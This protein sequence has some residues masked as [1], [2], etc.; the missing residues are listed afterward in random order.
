MFH[1]PVRQLWT[2]YPEMH[3]KLQLMNLEISSDLSSYE[4]N[5]CHYLLIVNKLN[6]DEDIFN[7]INCSNVKVI[8][9]Y[10]TDV[11]DFAMFPNMTKLHIDCT[12]DVE[13]KFLLNNLNISSKLTQLTI[14]TNSWDPQD[15]EAIKHIIDNH[16]LIKLKI[17]CKRYFNEFYENSIINMILNSPNKTIKTIKLN[18]LVIK[19]RVI[20]FNN[21]NETELHQLQD[22][23]HELVGQLLQRFRSIR[24]IK[25]PK[26]AGEEYVN[27]IHNICQNVEQSDHRRCLNV[28]LRD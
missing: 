20:M 5:H 23:W 15:D 13:N 21:L 1:D 9:N 3:F 11:Y 19:K 6:E 26:A 18:R 2:K 14:K 7:I 12:S 27:V 4:R 28:V 16:P 8:R 22:N 17:H 24:V 10:S 25:L